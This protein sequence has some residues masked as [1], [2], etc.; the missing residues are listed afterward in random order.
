MPIVI[1]SFLAFD[2]NDESSRGPLEW[3]LNMRT[4]VNI[5]GNKADRI[6]GMFRLSKEDAVLFNVSYNENHCL[7]FDSW[8]YADRVAK[9]KYF[10]TGYWLEIRK[11]IDENSVIKDNFVD[12]FGDAGIIGTADRAQTIVAQWVAE[13]EYY[14]D[15]PGFKSK[16]VLAEPEDMVVNDE[17]TEQGDE[18]EDQDENE[19]SEYKDDDED[20]SSED[21]EQEDLHH[22]RNQP[23]TPERRHQPQRPSAPQKARKYKKRTLSKR[24]LQQQLLSIMEQLDHSQQEM[25]QTRKQLRM[26]RKLHF[27]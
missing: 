12:L 26:M 8:K 17:Q 18:D 5:R 21:G 9:E 6:Y 13:G 24:E 1:L 3:C 10:W 16:H 25:E 23:R 11:K 7:T 2:K 22:R 20:D 15:K 14:Q 27:E 19:D 4:A